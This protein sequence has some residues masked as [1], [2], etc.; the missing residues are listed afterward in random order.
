MTATALVDQATQ[1]LEDPYNPTFCCRY[2]ICLLSHINTGDE[3]WENPIA[4]DAPYAGNLKLSLDSMVN[5]PK[6]MKLLDRVSIFMTCDRS[7]EDMAFLAQRMEHCEC[8]RT[9]SLVDSMHAWQWNP[10]AFDRYPEGFTCR[11]TTLGGLIAIIADLLCAAFELKRSGEDHQKQWPRSRTDCLG[12]SDESA[13]VMFCRWLDEY[14]ILPILRAVGASACLFARGIIVPFLLSAHLPKNLVAILKRGV[15]S[16]PSD[17]EGT[18]DAFGVLYPITCVFTTMRDIS[19][20]DDG[21]STAYFFREHCSLFL[22]TLNRIAAIDDRLPWSMN[23]TW[24]DGFS[25]GGVVHAKLVLPFDET[26]Y[27]SKILDWSRLNRM[28][29]LAVQTPYELARN[30]MLTLAELPAQCMNARCPNKGGQG[31]FMMCSGCKRVV[32]C[33][34]ECQDKDWNGRLPHKS[35]CKK[36][37]VLGDAT[38]IPIYATPKIEP[39]Q[40]EISEFQRRV[41]ERT[42]LSMVS[43]MIFNENCLPDDRIRRVVNDS[44]LPSL[45][46]LRAIALTNCIPFRI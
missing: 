37:R 38:G 17:F 15:D 7:R 36:I 34:A 4:S 25:M 24:D 30:V 28:T 42:G 40:I 46:D 35:V 9:D 43:L 12:D 29:I 13:A 33:S 44:E 26:K 32:Y 14:P 8:D 5:L 31:P 10:A 16:I 20:I 1:S 22:E 19:N 39:P 45:S 18:M 21:V 23:A 6:S 41:S 3:F 11:T 2:Y 27:H